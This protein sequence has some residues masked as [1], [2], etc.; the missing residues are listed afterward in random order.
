[1][2]ITSRYRIKP[3]MLD[4]LLS[5]GFS[6]LRF[7]V[8]PP[9]KRIERDT[10]AGLYG[11]ITTLWFGALFDNARPAHPFFNHAARRGV[12]RHLERD[13]GRHRGPDEEREADRLGRGDRRVDPAGLDPLVRRLGRGVRPPLPGARRRRDL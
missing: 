2:P 9:G 13:D 10:L 4:F 3:S 1:M 12:E 7:P 11:R 6:R 5:C 8:L